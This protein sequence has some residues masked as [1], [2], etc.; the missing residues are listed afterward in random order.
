M[1]NF[2]SF[3]EKK[4][5]KRLKFQETISGQDNFWWLFPLSPLSH[6]TRLFLLEG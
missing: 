1:N 2:I 3:Q 6:I 4:K 5:K